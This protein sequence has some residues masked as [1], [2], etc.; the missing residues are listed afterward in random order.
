MP[1]INIELDDFIRRFSGR[2]GKLMWLLGAGASIAAGIPSAWNMIQ[3][4]KQKLYTSKNHVSPKVINDLSNPA[5]CR[6]LQNFIDNM[7]SYPPEGDPEEYAALFEAACPTELDRQNY[8]E[9]NIS[10]GKPSYGHIALATLM[11][12]NW[13]RIVWTTNFD[14][15]IADACSK[16]Y[17]STMQLASVDLD[18]F[19]KLP[20]LINNERWPIEIKLHGD[21]RSRRLKNTAEELRQQDASLRQQLINAC[22]RFGLIVAG[23]S[24]RDSSIMEAIEKGLDS[25]SPFPYGLFWLCRGTANVLPAVT[26]LI[27]RA[28]AQGV[29]CALV[30]IESFDETL[31]DI[32]SFLPSLDITCLD[33]FAKRSIWSA[34]P[35]PIGDKNGFPV[36]RLNAL[37]VAKLPSRC[38]LIECSIDGQKKLDEAISCSGS[39]IF[40]VRV[41]SG[42]LAFG[43]DSDIRKLLTPYG[44][45]AFNEHEI[46]LGRLSRDTQEKS[47]IR[48]ALSH[49]IAHKTDM[50][51]IRKRNEDFLFPKDVRNQKW[52]GLKSLVRDLSGTLAA[53]S[54]T[55]WREGISFR[56]EL[57]GSELWLTYEPRII[58][59]SATAETLYART[60]FANKRTATRYNKQLNSLLSFWGELLTCG[61]RSISLGIQNGLDATFEIEGHAVQS[62]RWKG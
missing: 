52:S 6:L 19:N 18:S 21:F 24:G 25:P 60:E 50:G 10:L 40:A 8:I 23:Y 34:P 9:K 37:K 32:I 13:T 54:A 49:G 38:R 51:I 33:N 61:G 28:A 35:A 31:R 53:D 57:V 43:D 48:Q 5:I 41:S 2:S 46:S 59:S 26:N 36:I 22:Q 7:G 45:T 14:H 29:E 42:V 27:D 15:L 1:N 55:R 47:L 11:C 16:V 39:N 56:L 30:N 44:I 58:F 12:N 4:F 3:E 20:D 17:G 62:W